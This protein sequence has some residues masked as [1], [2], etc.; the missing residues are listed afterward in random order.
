MNEILSINKDNLFLKYI[1]KRLCSPEYR[2]WHIS[3]HNRYDI[4]YIKKILQNI[5]R[6]AGLNYFAIPPGDYDRDDTLSVDFQEYQKIVDQTHSEMGRGTINSLKKNFFPDLKKMGLLEIK[7]KMS[8]T[9]EHVRHG[10]LTKSAVEFVEATTLIEE[11]KKFTDCIDKLFGSKISE[12]AE[13]INLSDYANDIVSIYE[14][15]FIFS[16]NNSDLDKIGLLNSYRSLRKYERSKVIDLV[17]EYASPDNFKGNK[18]VLRDFHNWKNQAQQIMSLLKTTV[19]FA[20]DQNKSF[21]ISTGST[22]FFQEPSKRSVIPKHEYFTFHQIERKDKFELHHIV[23]ISWARNKNEAKIIDDYRNL[24]YIHRSQHKQISR[25]GNRN[26]VLNI[27][28]NE[29]IFSDIEIKGSVK[30]T[31]GKDAF[32]SREQNKIKKIAKY[33]ARL[34]QSILEF[35]QL[36][37]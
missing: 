19:Y 27:N 13:T 10:I 29:A 2:G 37:E 25:N 11:Y 6:V 21:R 17:K 20:V 23:P 34:L 33:N 1:V 15:M 12:L 14:F 22:G 9:G 36:Q 4:N 3:Q 5:H 16:D 32:Y 7:I 8:K 35:E 18:T 31:N 24:I 30:T 28:P 26:V